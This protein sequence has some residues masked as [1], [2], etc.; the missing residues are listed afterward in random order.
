M[1][2]SYLSGNILPRLGK[3]G[4]AAIH[5]QYVLLIRLHTSPVGVNGGSAATYQYV[6][7]SRLHTSPVGKNGGSGAT[8]SVCYTCQVTYF[9]G[10]G[11]W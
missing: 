2:Y 1:L 10:W 7:L 4:V 3:M 6:I 11:K 9:P 8:Y 5:I